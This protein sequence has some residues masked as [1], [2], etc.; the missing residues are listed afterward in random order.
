MLGALGLITFGIAMIVLRGRLGR[1]LR[2][3]SGMSSGEEFVYFALPGAFF[4]VFGGLAVVAL[5]APQ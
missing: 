2:P 3:P 4:I 5:V 1:S